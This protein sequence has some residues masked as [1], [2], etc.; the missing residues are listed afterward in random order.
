VDEVRAAET[1]RAALQRMAQLE[2][3]AA[4]AREIVRETATGLP[5]LD[6]E[7]EDALTELDADR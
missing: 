2:R 1:L 5:H 3:V 7:L 4:V 6:A